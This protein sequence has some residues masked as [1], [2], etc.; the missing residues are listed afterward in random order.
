MA[1]GGMPDE[2]GPQLLKEKTEEDFSRVCDVRRVNIS[3][4]LVLSYPMQMWCHPA[5]DLSIIPTKIRNFKSW[6]KACHRYFLK[7]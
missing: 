6:T 1:P 7:C 5:L 3:R 4:I 2:A